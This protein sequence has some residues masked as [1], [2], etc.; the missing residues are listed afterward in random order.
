MKLL[1]FSHR[2]LKISDGEGKIFY[3]IRN[4]FFKIVRE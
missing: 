1:K 3:R 4:K 2:K